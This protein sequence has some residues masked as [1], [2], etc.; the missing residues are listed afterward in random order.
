MKYPI[1]THTYTA[2]VWGLFV[3]G[4]TFPWIYESRGEARNIR[5]YFSDRV[6]RRIKKVTVSWKG[7]AF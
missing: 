2:H 5:S 7:R 6:K 4:E 1:I 3:P